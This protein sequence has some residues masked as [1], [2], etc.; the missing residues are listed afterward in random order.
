MI[1]EKRIVALFRQTGGGD[2]F[3]KPADEFTDEQRAHLGNTLREE[4]VLIASMQSAD[5]WFALTPLHLVSKDHTALRK[6]ALPDIEWIVA[7]DHDYKLHGGNL[8]VR[9]RNGSI[10]NIK[11]RSGS[12][13]VSLMNVLMYIARVAG[14]PSDRVLSPAWRTAQ[15]PTTNDQ[16]H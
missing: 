14:P 13:Y 16:R 10:V 3:T 11:L 12:A 5:A 1:S 9:L 15:R 6:V 7:T 4:R 2:E 8:G